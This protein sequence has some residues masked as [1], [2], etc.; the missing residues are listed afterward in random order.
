MS[1]QKTKKTPPRANKRIY[2]LWVIALLALGFII[3]SS[4]ITSRQHEIEREDRQKFELLDQKTADIEYRL[5]ESTEKGA[6]T[7]I[8][9]CNK[10]GTKFYKD[11]AGVCTI[12]IDLREGLAV[13]NQ[14][15]QE[16]IA[17]SLGSASQQGKDDFSG[18]EYMGFHEVLDGV[19]CSFYF[20]NDDA[21]KLTNG[22]L[23]CHGE[24]LSMHYE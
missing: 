21:N 6:W 1:K 18:V 8:K 11:E 23:S 16:V 15:A 17:S 2:A 22:S 14:A 4:V 9:G 20:N 3:Y 5:N 7:R 13:D 12:S 24:S 19:Y 10:P